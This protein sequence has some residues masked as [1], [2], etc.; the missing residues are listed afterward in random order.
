MRVLNGRV[1]D[2][3][4]DVRPGSPTFGQIDGFALERKIMDYKNPYR[5]MYVPAGFAH[6]FIAT[7]DTLIEYLAGAQH[8]PG[9]EAA[10][11]PVAE[12]IDWSVCNP[13]LKEEFDWIVYGEKP[14][15]DSP[16]AKKSMASLRTRTVATVDAGEGRKKINKDLLLSDRDRDGFTL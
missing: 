12:D 2:F 8:S 14:Q 9:N 7:E 5:W 15:G 10:I 13:E 11:S 4:I 16:T 3:V 1:L 6:G